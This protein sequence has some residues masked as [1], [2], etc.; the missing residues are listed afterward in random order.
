MDGMTRS[1]WPGKVLPKGYRYHGTPAENLD[2]IRESGLQPQGWRHNDEGDYQPTVFFS[3]YNDPSGAMMHAEEGGVLLRVKNDAPLKWDDALGDPVSREPVPPSALELFGDDKQWHPL[4][5]VVSEATIAEFNPR[6]PRDRRGRWTATRALGTLPTDRE[7]MDALLRQMGHDPA[8]MRDTSFAELADTFPALSETSLDRMAPDLPMLGAFGERMKAQRQEAIDTLKELGRKYPE[9]AKQV[10]AVA[11]GPE[12]SPGALAQTNG[13]SEIRYT[14]SVFASPTGFAAHQSRQKAV[15]QLMAGAGSSTPQY[16][17]PLTV[18]YVTAHEFGHVMAFR[19]LERDLPK[20]WSVTASLVRPNSTYGWTSPHENLAELFATYHVGGTLTTEQRGFV[21]AFIRDVE[22]GGGTWEARHDDPPAPRVRLVYAR[23]AVVRRRLAEAE[24]RRFPVRRAR[25]DRARHAGSPLAVSRRQ[26][27]QVRAGEGQAPR[28]SLVEHYGPGPHRSGSPQRVHG[29]GSF[30]VRVEY[31]GVDP[32]KMNQRIIKTAAATIADLNER[33]GMNVALRVVSFDKEHPDTFFRQMKPSKR[34]DPKNGDRYEDVLNLNADMMDN[35]TDSFIADSYRKSILSGEVFGKASA[36]VTS[37]TVHEYGHLAARHVGASGDRMPSSVSTQ[38]MSPYGRSAPQEGHAE[39][40]VAWYFGL[41]GSGSWASAMPI[42]PYPEMSEALVEHLPGQH[43]QRRHGRR[44]AGRA[45]TPADLGIDINGPVG[46]ALWRW[47]WSW[48]PI[49][50]AAVGTNTDP[51][52]L[53]DVATIDAA[54]AGARNHGAIPV[55]RGLQPFPSWNGRA[56]QTAIDPDTGEVWTMR[57]ALVGSGIFADV[58]GQTREEFFDN[59][60]PSLLGRTMTHP[61][62]M[63]TSPGREPPGLFNDAVH[64]VVLRMNV[65]RGV[66]A[67]NLSSLSHHADEGEVLVER[68]KSLRVTAATREK[69]M[70]SWTRQ[71][72]DRWVL[73]VEVVR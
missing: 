64:T 71:S 25:P 26:R 56:E 43:D 70:D 36:P 28:L 3:E 1:G 9:T 20:D 31:D 24:V 12:T 53:A 65:P 30:G 34:A 35:P 37:L 19:A 69:R 2:S 55:S 27:D 54:L 60:G 68:G 15:E 4:L 45:A 22:G 49:S 7:G 33:T 73:D 48:G 10:R 21:E 14:D 51:R 62:F 40:F 58:R 47:T 6:Q 46:Q 50:S 8:S 29:R 13:I 41:E 38:G 39:G 18:R 67:I 5:E 63:A 44:G 57:G 72:Y 11:V 52:D 16:G 66:G 23:Q 17:A 32:S 42:P 59:I 61:G